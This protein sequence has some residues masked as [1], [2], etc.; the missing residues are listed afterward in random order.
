MQ[1]YLVEYN[2]SSYD[3]TDH[4][5]IMQLQ[6]SHNQLIELRFNTGEFFYKLTNAPCKSELVQP[7]PTHAAS[8]PRRDAG[9]RLAG[10]QAI[11]RPASQEGARRNRSHAGPTASLLGGRCQRLDA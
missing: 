1:R 7:A 6:K 10:L 9:L 5:F 4:L 3:A 8:R 11:V 2:K